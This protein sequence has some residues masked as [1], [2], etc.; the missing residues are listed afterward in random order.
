MWPDLGRFQNL[1]LVGSMAIQNYVLGFG[2]AFGI[3]TEPLDT[4]GHDIVRH[5]TTQ[6]D[7]TRHDL[8]RFDTTRHDTT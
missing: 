8:T 4:T 6:R 7:T 3:A 2:S 5:D 1:L